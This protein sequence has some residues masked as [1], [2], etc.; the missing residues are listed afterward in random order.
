MNALNIS[1]DRL[2]QLRHLEAHLCERIRGQDHVVPRVVA[3][4]HRGELGLTTATRPRGSFLFLGPTGVGKT[5]LSI[6][7]TEYLL[8]DDKL[9]RFDM[10]EHQTQESVGVLIGGRV[11][12]VGL[13]GM[14]RAKSATGTL[15]FDEIE[16]A[17]PRVLD[18]FLQILD[19][20]RVTM[21]SGET[22][23]LSGFYV[24]FTSNIA[25]SEILT[26][27]HS[28]FTTMERHVLAKAQR[29]LRPELYARIAEKLVFNRLSYDVQMEI[30]RF[31]IERELSFLRDKGFHLVASQQLVAFIMQRGFH[32]RLGARPLRDA[33]EKHL[34]GAVADVML[35]EVRARTFELVV[36]GSE[37]L[38]RPCEAAR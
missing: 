12:E 6:A 24:V 22:L 19:A 38:L 18:L 7:F 20:A 27:Q 14:A 10:S 32:P 26:L 4:L 29:T 17:H 31:H 30:A 15:L 37:L 36:R 16:K 34:R 13:L 3:A 21:A 33:I 11:G 23:D 28:S 25:A 1:A 35:A 8:G 5:E 9:F 2:E